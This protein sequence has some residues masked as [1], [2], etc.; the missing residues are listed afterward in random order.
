LPD[1][2]MPSTTIKRPLKRWGRNPDI[3]PLY[4]TV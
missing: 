2:S 3:G 4:D 1:P